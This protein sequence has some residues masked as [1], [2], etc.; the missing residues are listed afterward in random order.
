MKALNLTNQRYGRLVVERSLGSQDGRTLWLCL[1]DCGETTELIT[2]QLRTKRGTKSCGCSK[3][4]T[5]AK[6]IRWKG[7]EE[8]PGK[9][10]SHIRSECVRGSRILPFEIG[11]EQ[12]WD[13]FLKQDRK[14]ALTGL[15]IYFNEKSTDERTAS[16]DRIDSN[17][18]YIIDNVQWVHKDVNNMKQDY[19]QDYFLKICK[20]IAKTN[21]GNK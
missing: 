1:C 9:Y 5:R 15:D 2:A 6:N 11:I 13:L 7:H 17:K 20:L 18:G 14:C 21:K 3:K 19:E 16:L 12:I 10:F 8:I 4:G